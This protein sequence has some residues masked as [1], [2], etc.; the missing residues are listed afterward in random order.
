MTTRRLRAGWLLLAAGL[1]A[2]ALLPAQVAAKLAP[3]LAPLVAA[4]DSARFDPESGEECTVGVAA[5]RATADG[6][7]LLWKNRDAKVHDNV[8]TA[9]DD[10]TWPYVG[11]CNAGSKTS[12]WGGANAKG[13]CIM[14]SVSRDLP[15]GSKKGPDN[16]PFMKLALATCATVEDFE[17]LLA[18]TDK[19]GRRTRANFGVI[20]GKGAAAFFETSHQAYRRYDANDSDNGI[21]VR[22]NFAFTGGGD[23]GRERFQRAETLCKQLPTDGKLELTWLLREFV[24]DLTPPRSAKDGGHGRQD[25]RE[26]IH[27]QTTVAAMVFHGCRTDQDPM[28]TAMWAILGQ[29][30]FSV[31]VP[32]WPALGRVAPELAG[33]PKSPLCNAAIALQTTFYQE[34]APSS[35]ATDGE[36]A[37]VA[38]ANR[39]LLTADLPHV[40]AEVLAVEADIQERSATRWQQWSDRKQQPSKAQLYA[41]HAELAGKASKAVQ[42]LAEKFRPANVR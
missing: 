16:G 27:R 34:P 3:Q 40:C 10:G 37:D 2:S 24:R 29:P 13:F 21:L 15:Q 12:V 7:P 5:G 11:I 1:L 35:K 18:R 22:A 8:V 6:R 14:N 39:W 17:A 26:T 33:D 19:S 20:D 36:A 30:L 9:F 32:C 23:G 4:T 28:A 38:G 41:L 25:V 42:R 31:A